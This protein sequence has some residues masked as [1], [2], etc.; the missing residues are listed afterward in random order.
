[1]V[2]ESPSQPGEEG[3]WG[4]GGEMCVSCLQGSPQGARPAAGNPPWYH[5]PDTPLPSPRAPRKPIWGL[6]R[7]H[8]SAAIVWV[9]TV[10][11]GSASA[12]A[13]PLR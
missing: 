6:S 9:E 4:G 3:S 12:A 11:C 8:T 5:H 7:I 10:L 2:L 1:M 13:V